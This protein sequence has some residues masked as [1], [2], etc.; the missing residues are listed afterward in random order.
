MRSG[1]RSKNWKGSSRGEVKMVSAR[2]ADSK[3]WKTC[4]G[5]MVNLIDEAAFKFTPDGIKM[6]AMD[7]S[8]VALLDFELPAS[9]FEE[10]KIKQPTTL[11]IGL[12]EMNKILARAKAEDELALELDEEKNRLTLT[13][14]GVSTRRLSLPLIDVS[15]AE[16]P[17]PKLQFT[18]TADV[19]AGVIQ[20]GLK[21]AEIVGDN[22]KFELSEDGFFLSAE[23]DKGASELK[24]R[25]GDQALPKLSV[26]QPAHAMFNIKYLSDM[27]KAAG[28]SDVITINLGT[29]LPIQLDLQVA[30]G[31]GRLRFLLAPRIEAE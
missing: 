9:A 6:K 31:K 23:S 13:F 2:M 30:E 27:A 24:L 26:K 7:P 20:D 4:V 8:H 5:A 25:K 16:L 14:K 19:V 29:D 18:A 10:Y 11:G 3:T 1:A 17:E 12:T 15:E 28:S 21:D 22:V